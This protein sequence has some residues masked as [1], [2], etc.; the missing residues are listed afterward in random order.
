[1]IN[2]KIID[3]DNATYGDTI[4]LVSPVTLYF[5]V[6]GYIPTKKVWKII[7]DFGNGNQKT[8]L[9]QNS[10]YFENLTSLPYQ[11]EP[12]DPRNYIVDNHYYFEDGENK[13]YNVSIEFYRIGIE[14]PQILKF[15]LNLRLP[16]FN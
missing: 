16:I 9:L 2:K 15:D 4:N 5:S 3:I 10:T 13:I 8:Q 11:D 12:G 6:S 7:Y 1:M 14:L